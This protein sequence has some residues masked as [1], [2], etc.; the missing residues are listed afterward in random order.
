MAYIW[1]NLNSTTEGQRGIF[2]Y[3]LFNIPGYRLTTSIVEDGDNLWKGQN[4][5]E[6]SYGGAP[7]TSSWQELHL[8]AGT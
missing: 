4:S 7:S 8:V 1:S 5:G 6:E 2:L 3:N